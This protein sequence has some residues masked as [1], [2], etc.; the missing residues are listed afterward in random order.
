MHNIEDRVDSNAAKL[1]KL[2]LKKERT[3]YAKY[4]QKQVLSNAEIP[5]SA[6]TYESDKPFAEGGFGLVYKATYAGVAVA[7]KVINL[8]GALT[9]PAREKIVA[10]AK[11]ELGI[12][13]KLRYP[14]IVEV[15]GAITTSPDEVS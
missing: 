12:M 11:K 15:L 9:L 1:D 3:D 6:L 13:H 4:E 14:C 7:V 2:N 10:Q 8:G 5:V